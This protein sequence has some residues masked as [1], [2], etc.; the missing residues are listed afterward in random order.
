MKQVWAIA[1]CF[2]LFVGGCRTPR[3]DRQMNL[4][5]PVVCPDPV[6][7][8]RI[9]GFQVFLE[10]ASVV[11]VLDVPED[12]G[13]STWHEGG[14]R[15]RVAGSCWHGAGLLSDTTQFPKLV[16]RRQTSTGAFVVPRAEVYCTTD[17]D[18][19]TSAVHKVE[20]IL[21]K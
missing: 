9:F 7:E 20:M 21:G 12:W 11:S 19:V 17:Y 2:L 18:V 10:D 5:F 15:P 3:P 14:A 13:I 4:S 8:G 16:I 6:S 1:A